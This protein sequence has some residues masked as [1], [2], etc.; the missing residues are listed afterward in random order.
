MIQKC[1][2]SH[3]C[4][5][6]YENDWLVTRITTQILA[7][8]VKTYKY[9][10]WG[11]TEV[12][13]RVEEKLEEIELFANKNNDNDSGS[14]SDSDEQEQDD[15]DKQGQDEH[16]QDGEDEQDISV[17]DD[18]KDQQAE[19][20]RTP[21]NPHPSSLPPN[22]NTRSSRGGSLLWDSREEGEEACREGC[23][24]CTICHKGLPRR[25]HLL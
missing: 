16:E 9:K 22:P 10:D 5:R 24:C 21:R 6:L 11:I 2:E 20:K 15:Q 13:E 4:L 18:N 8:S 25:K 7:A 1:R 3:P 23:R 19:P 14:D 12:R 17:P